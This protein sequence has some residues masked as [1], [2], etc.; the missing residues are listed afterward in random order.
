MELD[1]RNVIVYDIYALV[2]NQV[3]VSPMGD[4]IDLDH[5]AVLDDIKLYVAADDVKET[6]ENILMCFNIER[7]FVK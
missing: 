1:E 5:R 3:R 6:F 2:R 7:E 4:V